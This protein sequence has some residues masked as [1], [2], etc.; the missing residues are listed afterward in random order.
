MPWEPVN[1]LLVP[2]IPSRHKS[3]TRHSV[4][5]AYTPG[6]AAHNIMGRRFPIQARIKAVICDRSTVWNILS[7]NT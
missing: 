7:L 2:N 1:V 6:P 5:L 4:V 3:G